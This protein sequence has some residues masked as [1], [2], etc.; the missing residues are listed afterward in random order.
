MNIFNMVN[1]NQFY[2]VD[3]SYIIFFSGYSAFSTYKRNFDIQNSSLYPKFDPTLDE[4]FCEI[5]QNT[6]TYTIK[7]PLQSINPFINMSNVIFCTDC[8]RKNI[9]RREFYP[10]YKINRDTKDTSKD[11]FDFGKVFN[12]A[13][14]IAIPNLCEEYGCII[15]SCECAEGDDVIAVLTKKIL[16]DNNK[17]KVIIISSDRDMLQ[18]YQDRVTIITAQGQERTPVKDIEKLVKIKVNESFSASDFLLFKILIGDGADNIPN[19]KSG[20]GNKKALALVNDREKLKKMLI[21][22]SLVRES[23]SRNKRLISMN[24]IP[25]E[26]AEMILESYNRALENRS[27]I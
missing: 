20:I 1:G 16:S 4:E 17:N 23:F 18:L 26:V 21:E 14:K 6:L 27:V 9:W 19:V 15:V 22:D 5:F 13:K 3:L 24:E 8:A 11:E 7:K 10:D 12:Y 2:I 25:G